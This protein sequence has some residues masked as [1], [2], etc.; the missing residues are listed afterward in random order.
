[1]TVFVMSVDDV[2]NRH[3][4]ICKK[5]FPKRYESALSFHNENDTLLSIAG[6][7]LI[8]RIVRISEKDISYTKNNKPCT[9]KHPTFFNISH[10]G[11]YAVLVASSVEVGVDIE[12][13]ERKNLVCARR[14]FTDFEREWM[15]DDVTKFSIL[16]TLKESVMKALGEGLRLPARDFDI[17]PFLKNESITLNGTQLN[18]YTTLY[19]GY[20]VSVCA[21]NDT[22]NKFEGI[23][24]ARIS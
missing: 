2:D 13:A 10:S 18:A 11:K 24:I 1:M 12:K 23:D 17:M 9:T 20:A 3:R 15:N 7:Y 5:Y 22:D 19:D 21:C 4:D 8:H 6:A 14:V 16:W